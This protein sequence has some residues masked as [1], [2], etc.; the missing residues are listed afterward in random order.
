MFNLSTHLGLTGFGCFLIVVTRMQPKAAHTND[1]NGEI[2]YNNGQPNSPKWRYEKSAS[3]KHSAVVLQN[4]TEKNAVRLTH[5]VASPQNQ[6][7]RPPPTVRFAATP[8][9]REIV[10]LDYTKPCNCSQ[11]SSV[12][13]SV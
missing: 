6:L 10:E 2:V 5:T 11:K 4:K 13:L 3:P 8:Q 1:T 9:T 7:L 12:T